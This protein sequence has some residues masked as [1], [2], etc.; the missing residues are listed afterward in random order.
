MK[1]RVYIDN[2]CG[3]G[4]TYF[5]TKKEA[6]EYLPK[7]QLSPIYAGIEVRLEKRVCG[8]WIAI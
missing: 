3:L 4:T 1:W 8:Q 5:K 2:F 7:A 6:M